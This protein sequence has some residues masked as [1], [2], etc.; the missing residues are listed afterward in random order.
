MNGLLWKAMG[1]SNSQTVML[2]EKELVR[3]GKSTKLKC[4]CNCVDFH[5]K[6]RLQWSKNIR[7]KSGQVGSHASTKRKKIIKEVG[8]TYVNYTP[9]GVPFIVKTELKIDREFTKEEHWQDAEFNSWC[10]CNGQGG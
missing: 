7:I 6:R 1:S 2:D 9:A 8:K 5:R 10:G 4:H 3:K